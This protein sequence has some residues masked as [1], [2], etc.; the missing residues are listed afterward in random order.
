MKRDFE[1]FNVVPIDSL[2][3]GD[4]FRMALNFQCD[5]WVFE[6]FNRNLQMFTAHKVDDC[7]LVRYFMPNRT[8][9]VL[10]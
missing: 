2:N 3:R 4:L 1:Y 6:G 7:F 9:C 8:V 5:E 10:K